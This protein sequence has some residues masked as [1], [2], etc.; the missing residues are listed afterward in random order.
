MK[1]FNPI[2]G[3][4]DYS[5]KQAKVREIVRQKILENLELLNM[6][7]GGDNLKLMF[8]TIKRGDKLDLTK[9]D[10]VA[11]SSLNSSILIMFY[12]L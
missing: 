6:S 8:K 1:N 5:P 9:P 7:D 12:F 4:N 10:F 11:K 2:R 3:T